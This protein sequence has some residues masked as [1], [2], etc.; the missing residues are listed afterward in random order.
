MQTSNTQAAVVQNLKDAGCN[1]DII[2]QFMSCREAGR[3]QDSLR[4]LALHRKELLDEMHTSQSKL[5]RL[6]YLI[7]QIKSSEGIN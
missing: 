5:D 3:T 2:A 1:A 4:V 7:Y 6:D